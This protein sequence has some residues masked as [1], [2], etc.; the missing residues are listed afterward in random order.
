MTQQNIKVG[1]KIRILNNAT[2]ECWKTGIVEDI[3][4]EYAWVKYGYPIYGMG[5]AIELSQLELLEV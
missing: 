2:E 4:E 3:H 5:G 1:D